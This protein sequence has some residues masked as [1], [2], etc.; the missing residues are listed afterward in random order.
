MEHEKANSSLG[1]F[2]VSL[3]VVVVCLFLF[4]FGDFVCVGFFVCLFVFCLLVVGVL[5][6]F[7]WVVFFYFFFIELINKTQK[8][9]YNVCMIY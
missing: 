2:F 9:P 7:L 1:L 8:F 3:I 6:S 4:V 5:F